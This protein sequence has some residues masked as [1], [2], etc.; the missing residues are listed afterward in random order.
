MLG[1]WKTFYVWCFI[2][3][4]NT[5]EGDKESANACM[6]HVV[7]WRVGLDRVLCCK[8]DAAHRN[9]GQDA[10]LKILQSQDVV[11]ALSKP[12]ANTE[13]RAR[14]GTKQSAKHFPI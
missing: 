11:A 1:L 10:E 12:D 4:T 14:V 7:S 9:D 8:G 13:M 6:P 5:L 2:D 3:K